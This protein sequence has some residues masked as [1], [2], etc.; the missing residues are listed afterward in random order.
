MTY[1]S[2]T[3]IKSHGRLKSSN[4]V[5]DNRWTLKITGEI[6]L[7]LQESIFNR[8]YVLPWSFVIQRTLLSVQPLFFS[9]S[10]S[11]DYGMHM[12]KSN[13]HGVPKFTPNQDRAA[14]EAEEGIENSIKS[15][16]FYTAPEIMRTGVTHP[17]HV[18]AGTIQGD[19]YR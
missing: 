1:L 11:P 4:C 3:H 9:P 5:V 18:G 16:L 12:Y 14:E 6:T 15:A 17:D 7:R 19:M 13:Q 8:K 2:G 10:L